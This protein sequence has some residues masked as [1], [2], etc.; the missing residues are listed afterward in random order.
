[1]YRINKRALLTK[2]LHLTTSQAS[3]LASYCH[4]TIF[5]LKKAS[6]RWGCFQMQWPE[7]ARRSPSSLQKTAHWLLRG[8]SDM[9]PL[10]HSFLLEAGKLFTRQIG[11]SAKAQLLL[12]TMA[13][14]CSSIHFDYSHVSF[15]S[16]TGTSESTLQLREEGSQLLARVTPHRG[17][18]LHITIEKQPPALWAPPSSAHSCAT[19]LEGS[20]H[21][22][23]FSQ[24]FRIIHLTAVLQA[25][26]S[27]CI[28]TH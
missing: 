25:A 24:H 11:T 17:L 3:V 20:P 13:A 12:P 7:S 2:K 16:R 22:G 23:M 28:Y 19:R 15:W 26:L 21:H 4:G 18:F 1:M 5:L 9:S 8:T 14:A 10:S 6:P 27:T